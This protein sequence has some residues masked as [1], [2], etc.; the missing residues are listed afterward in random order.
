MRCI[1]HIFGPVPSRRLGLSLGVDLLE[2]KHCN[3][4][5]VYCELG[6]TPE[7]CTERDVF[8][9]TDEVVREIKEYFDSGK[10]ADILTF[11][12]NGEPLLAE[13]LGSVINAVRKFYPGRI[14]IL[15]NGVLLYDKRAARGAALADIVL[16]SIDAGSKDIFEKINRPGA[17]FEFERYVKGLVKFSGTFRGEIWVEVLLVKGINDSDDEF[18][19]IKK[20][21]DRMDNVT[22]IQVNTI[23]RSRAEK[24]AEPAAHERLERAAEIFGDIAEIIR[25]YEGSA[26]DAVED[27]RELIL[28]IT[29]LRPVSVDDMEKL[30][31]LPKA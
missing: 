21:I 28:K 8:A 2:S 26:I 22:R 31:G 14:A 5:C 4:N 12:G 29:R 24:S 25:G 11:S 13:N 3:L 23:V 18:R 1:M 7:I 30:T 16:P 17:G 19:N 27:I 6:K 9:E 20:I 10:R 15:T